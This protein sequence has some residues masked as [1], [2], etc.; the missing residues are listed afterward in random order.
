MASTL[1]KLYIQTYERNV[2]QRAQQGITRLMPWV[3]SKSVQGQAHN[4]DLIS[5]TAA[6][7][8][9]ARK[10]ATPDN[11]TAFNRRQSVVK[12]YHLGDVSEPEDLVQMLADPNSAYAIAHGKAMRRAH[13]D[14]I[15]T[16]A[17]GASRDGD[18]NSV[19]FD[20]NQTVGTGAEAL[21]FDIVRSVVEKFQENDIDPDEAKC[22]VISPAK[23]YELLGLAEATNADF[24]ALRPLQSKGYVEGWMGFD[25]IV[26]TRLGVPSVGQRDC[27]AMTKTA[28]GMQLNKPIWSRIEEDP[29][30]SFATRIYC[31]SSFGAVRVQDEQLVRV[32]LAEA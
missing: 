17:T 9:S 27:F 31:A 14:E 23:A 13:D 2:I 6:V 7:Q 22:F 1:D 20:A 16:A 26:S 28:L 18:G 30:I 4:W 21:T 3:M 11:E 15:I 5:Q 32:H 19:A 29:S 10:V 8:K 25:W 12:T 24:N